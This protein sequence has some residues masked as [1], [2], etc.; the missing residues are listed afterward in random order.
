M[1]TVY[2]YRMRQ[3]FTGQHPMKNERAKNKTE[4]IT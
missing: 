4:I 1:T 2:G 3:D